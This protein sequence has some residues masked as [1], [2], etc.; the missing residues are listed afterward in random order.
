MNP[1]IWLSLPH[2]GE[3]EQ[4]FVKQAFDSNWVAPLGPNVDGF[5]RDLASFLEEDTHVAALSSGTAALHLALIL[6]NV[7]PGD[8]VI[9]QSMTFSASA[10]PIRYLG[11]IPIFIDSEKDTWNMD[12]VILEKAIIER[13]TKGKKPKAIIPVHLYGMP[14]KMNAIIAIGEK[15]DIPVIEDAAEALGSSINK[16]KC[17]TFGDMGVLSFNGNKIITT[18]GGG[19]LVSKNEKY[20][21]EATFLATQARDTAPHY[22][23]SQIGYNYRL[24]NISAGIGRGQMEVLPERIKQRRYNYTFYEKELKDLPGISFLSEPEGFYSNRWLTTILVDPGK[25]G[26]VTREHIRIELEKE[27]IESRPLWKPMHLQPVFKNYP[28]Y[29]NGIA[30]N[31]FANGLCLPSGSNLT[32]EELKRVIKCIMS[33]FNK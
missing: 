22:Q 23:H 18:S 32:N 9:C 15:Y 30:E 17:G 28:Y 29:G 26:G 25:S 16:K 12:P 10:N 3:S 5:E 13:I 7:Q 19:A 14:A 2:I 8:E 24:S 6:L 21:K 31:L 33:V 4:K 11:G 20:I 1:K 27:N